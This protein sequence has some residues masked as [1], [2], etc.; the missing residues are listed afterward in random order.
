MDHKQREIINR[1]KIIQ[2]KQAS[3]HKMSTEKYFSKIIQKLND[4]DFR[5]DEYYKGLKKYIINWN[6][7]I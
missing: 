5:K 6:N 1:G 3:D 4:I 2:E 7:K